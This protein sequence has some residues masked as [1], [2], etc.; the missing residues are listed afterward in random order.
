MI[1]AGSFGML[2]QPRRC[3]AVYAASSHAA[4]TR[5]LKVLKNVAVAL[6]SALQ[7]CLLRPLSPVSFCVIVLAHRVNW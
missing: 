2:P 4:P 6:S 7:H 1:G 3:V 5:T